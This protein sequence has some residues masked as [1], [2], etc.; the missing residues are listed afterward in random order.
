MG[1]RG[2]LDTA[3]LGSSSW[4]PC[5]PQGVKG[6]DDDDDDDDDDTA[7]H[8][9]RPVLQHCHA[10]LL[11]S[12]IFADISCDYGYGTV[13]GSCKYNNEPS[14]STKCGKFL[15]QFYNT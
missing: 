2:Q 9:R 6:T 11:W 13:A 7:L 1:S 14:D 3:T 4:M 5:A 10:P 15:T 12:H 8:T